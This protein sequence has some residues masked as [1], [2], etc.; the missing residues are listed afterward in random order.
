MNPNLKPQEYA[1]LYAPI[2]SDAIAMFRYT[3]QSL[4]INKHLKVYSKSI[5]INKRA[6]YPRLRT[7]ISLGESYNLQN[8]YSLAEQFVLNLFIDKDELRIHEIMQTVLNTF[9]KDINQFKKEYVYKDVDKKGL[10]F[11]SYFLNFKGIKAKW[12]YYSLLETIDRDVDELLNNSALLQ[13]YL[14]DIDSGILFLEDKTIKKLQLHVPNLDEIEFAFDAFLNP[15]RSYGSGGYSYYGGGTG[16]GG[17][18]SGGGFGGFGGGGFGGG[19]SGG[20]W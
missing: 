7:F 13:Q 18:Y 3:V 4:V 15:I 12:A 14:I 8:T 11:S 20:S 17:G 19:G 2:K 5:Y 10:C 1:F 9:D 6:K 16:G